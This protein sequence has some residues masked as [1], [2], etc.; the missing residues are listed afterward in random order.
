MSFG[1]HEVIRFI[2]KLI[3]VPFCAIDPGHRDVLQDDD[4]NERQT[5]RVVVKHGDKVVSRTLH[6]QQ[7]QQKGDDTANHWETNGT[8]PNKNTLHVFY[9][10][11]FI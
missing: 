8:I 10:T 6:E 9:R 7:A 1:G 5:S 2:N 4:H 3:T 11:N